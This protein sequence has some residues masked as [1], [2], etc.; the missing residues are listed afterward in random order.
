MQQAVEQGHVT[1]GAYL[2]EQ[3]GLVGSGAAAWV[4][5]DQ[6]SASLDPVEQAQEQD[7]VAVG[8]VGAD[9]QK[10]VGVL[11][12]LVAARRA[13]SPERQ[14]VAT[15][16]AGH[17]QARVGLDVPGAD[18]AFGQLVGQVLSL[19]RHLP[20]HVQCHGVGAMLV[21]DAAQAFA[22]I[23]DSLCHAGARR[24]LAALLAHVGVFEAPGG[25]QRHVRG[26]AFGA[27]P[28]EVARVLLVTADLDD[29]AIGNA[30][31]DAAANAT[32]GA[33]ATDFAVGHGRAPVGN[34]KRRRLP[35]LAEASGATRRLCREV[36]RAVDV[37]SPGSR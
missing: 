20:R 11:E 7:R 37:D 33:D 22:G 21:D 29:L 12:V 15:A 4:D 16:G 5:D 25:R 3:V 35:R 19:Q 24:L 17:A 8:H 10:H 27:Q 6:P 30:H 36:V 31:D 14:F 32:V 28:A 13:V 18:E 26:E 2:Q 9:H 23:G 1:A 34:A